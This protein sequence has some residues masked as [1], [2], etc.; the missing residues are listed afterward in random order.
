[1]NYSTLS[2]LFPSRRSVVH[3]T[4]GIVATSQPLATAAG[5]RILELGGNA[6][7]AAVAAGA[8][9]GVVEPHMTGLGGDLFAQFYSAK[10]KKTLGINGCGRSPARLS[11]ETLKKS[12][13]KGPRIPSTSIHSVTVPGTVAGWCDIID[14]WGNGKLTLREIL[15]P[16]IDLAEKGHP[17]SEISARKWDRSIEVLRQSKTPRAARALLMAN[18]QAPKEGDI[19]RN[20]Q[21]AQSLKIVAEGGRNAFYNSGPIADAIVKCMSDLGGLL[22][23]EDLNNH[24]SIFVNPIGIEVLNGENYKLWE[25]P[26]NGQGLVALSAIGA[27]K[28]LDQAKV[29]DLK[30]LQHNSLE[31]LHLIIENLKFAFRLADEYVSDPDYSHI[32]IEHL[33]SDA[34]F[35]AQ[36]K[37]FTA[38]TVHANYRYVLDPINKSDTVYLSTSDPEGNACSFINS[39]YCDFGSGIFPDGLGFPLQNRGANFN[40]TP[41]SRNFVSGNKRPY[42]TIIPAMVTKDDELYASYGIMGGFNQPQA[43]VQVLFNMILFGMNPQQAIDAPRICLACDP[44]ETEHDF[45]IGTDGPVSRP[46]TIVH[47][48]EGIREEVFKGLEALG[49]K[50]YRAKGMERTIFGC[51]QI[52]KSRKDDDILVYSAGSDP[53]GDGCA[54][55]SL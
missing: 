35:E 31:Y 54:F 55:P 15:Q 38:E 16:A 26:P 27:I 48:E 40:M 34:H 7:M 37:L 44:T 12:G 47:V 51:G 10:E 53:R 52:I 20:P 1:M 50:V 6:A 4:K 22:N 43:H 42:H 41:G 29:I 28:K 9:L 2:E 36:A 14:T 49:H 18:G 19:Y 33:L 13:I 30:S 5:I 25:I 45:G 46:T 3:S 32:P 11:I 21:L 39:V 23:Q 24:T 17:V 8:V